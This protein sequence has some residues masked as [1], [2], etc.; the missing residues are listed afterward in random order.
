MD[1]SELTQ[2]E[3]L[4]SQC[5]QQSQSIRGMIARITPGFVMT[6][7]NEIVQ[8]YKELKALSIQSSN[9]LQQ[10]S[11]KYAHDSEKFSK[12]LQGAERRLDRQLDDL[13]KMRRA[14]VMMP[15]S[16]SDPD[17]IQQQKRILDVIAMAQDSFNHEIDRLYDL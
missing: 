9:C 2:Y 17:M 13:S 14:L 5:E 3:A 10:L 12:M 7:G 15:A 16:S 8:G 1:N 4:D 11:M 6:H